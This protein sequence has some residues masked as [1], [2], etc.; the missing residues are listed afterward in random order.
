M[1]TTQEPPRNPA[2]D[3]YDNIPQSILDL[4]KRKI[5]RVEN[6]PLAIIIDRI[7]DFFANEQFSD[8]HIPGEKFKLFHE[9]EPLVSV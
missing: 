2:K 9:F 5:Y 7:Q 6:H 8:I 4:T 1:G 3:P